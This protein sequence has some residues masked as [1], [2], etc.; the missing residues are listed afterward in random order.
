[1]Q[2]KKRF[3][4]DIIHPSNVHYFKGLIFDLQGDGH[5]VIITARDKDITFALL[6]SLGLSFINLGKMKKN[7]SSKIFFLLKGELKAL[8]ILLRY[9]PDMVISMASMNFSHAAFVLR[10]PFFAFDD[11]E[12]A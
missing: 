6:K 3:L 7:L 11:T 5:T 12:H 2:M 4:F 1:M 8:K 9:K 10:I